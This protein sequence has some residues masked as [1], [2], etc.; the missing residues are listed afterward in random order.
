M[1]SGGSAVEDPC[2]S[3]EETRNAPQEDHV[4]AASA[5]E[6]G[7]EQR[8]PNVGIR[9]DPR[10]PA[11]ERHLALPVEPTTK[12]PAVLH[13]QWYSSCQ[14]QNSF[15]DMERRIGTMRHM[16]LLP[17]M[18]L[19]LSCSFIAGQGSNA[20]GT[21]SVDD[22]APADPTNVI[23]VLNEA[24]TAR[25]V[26]WPDGGELAFT[27]MDG[28]QY[29]LEVP[30]GALDAGTEIVMTSV[31]S[32]EGVPLTGPVFAVQLEPSGLIFNK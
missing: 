8:N 28:A 32:M 14:V 7:S 21:G 24:D 10:L 18:A 3:E 26:I 30:Q 6:D 31:Q 23:V 17:L 9:A 12:N 13:P 27:S 11:G 16:L 5:G 2:W 15:S 19:V 29:L 20:A 25:G 4:K 1:G 22:D